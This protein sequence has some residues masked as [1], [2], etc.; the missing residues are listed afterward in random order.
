MTDQ[1]RRT[2]RGATRQAPG[3]RRRPAQSHDRVSGRARAG[4]PSK[5]KA[6]DRV[7]VK[8]QSPRR[9]RDSSA[10]RPILRS[11]TKFAARAVLGLV[12]LAIFVFGVFPTGSYVEQRNELMDAEFELSDLQAENADLESRIARLESDEEIEKVAR[13][14]HGMVLPN[15]ESYLVLPPGE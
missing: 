4:R 9:S 8:A 6:N 2:A 15:E 14:E 7:P 11:L 5:L 3:P 13:E 1:Q 10:P 12:I